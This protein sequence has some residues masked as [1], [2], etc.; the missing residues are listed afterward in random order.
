MVVSSSRSC[1]LCFLFLSCLELAASNDFPAV[2]P[3][4]CCFID[5][6][7]AFVVHTTWRRTLKPA[8]RT[9]KRLRRETVRS[10]SPNQSP[11]V[12]QN[13]VR[14]S[15]RLNISSSA[16]DYA[17]KMPRKLQTIRPKAL[18]MLAANS[19]SN[20]ATQEQHRALLLPAWKPD[21]VIKKYRA[22][23]QRQRRS[24][25]SRASR[26]IDRPPTRSPP[27]ST[28]SHRPISLSTAPG[29]PPAP[30]GPQKTKSR[31]W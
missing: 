17:A 27:P 15:K 24:P 9:P 22:L 31:E 14:A 16:F 12:C 7:E 30:P 29:S 28:R 10:C 21:P 2:W 23:G 19:S 13:A 1:F 3:R 26:P 5:T 8:P 11:H 18:G 20:A 6:H 4:R 25:R